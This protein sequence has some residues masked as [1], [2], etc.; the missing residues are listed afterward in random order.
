MRPLVHPRRWLLASPLVAIGC[1]QDPF[2]VEG[3]LGRPIPLATG[4]DSPLVRLA[5]LDEGCPGREALCNPE[6]ERCGCP[7]GDASRACVPLLVDSLAP[8][9]TLRSQDDGAEA[10]SLSDECLEIR[11]AA[12]LA[13]ADPSAQDLAS[14]VTRIRL[15]DLPVVRAPSSGAG[16]WTWSAGDES[17][18]IEPGGVLGGNVLARFAVEV[19]DRTPL[20]PTFALYREFPGTEAS[21]ANDG[22]AFLPVQ[23]PGRLLGRSPNDECDIGGEGCAEP[24]Y[25]PFLQERRLALVASRMVLDS[26]VAVP[27]C[28]VAY[29][30]ETDAPNDGGVCAGDPDPDQ[31]PRGVTGGID[32][33]NCTRATDS[34]GGGRP[35]SL[36]VATSVPGLV[37]F[38]DSTARLF[39]DPATLPPCS[40]DLTDAR[41]CLEGSDGALHL[42]GWP[43]AS[44]LFRLRVR[45]LA[46][47]PGLARTS[48]PDP[49][50]R[51]DR[52]LMAL[53]GQCEAFPLAVRDEEDLRNTT[54]PYRPRVRSG[55]TDSLRSYARESLAVVGEAW[56][57]DDQAGPEADR[58]IPTL[59]LPAGHPAAV[60]VRQ[61]VVPEAVQPDGLVGT[62]LF[63]ETD[64]VLDYTDTSPG[65]RLR[66]TQPH[67]GDCLVAPNCVSDATPACCHGLPRELLL[68]FIEDVGDDACCTALST[69]DLREIQQ[70]GEHC[71]GI[72][73]L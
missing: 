24:A 67:S 68:T 69:T 48:G 46:I 65:I 25:D 70:R 49:C 3:Q 42:S 37:L 58:W 71:Q 7:E 64:T 30:R 18:V 54:P 28:H 12:G 59:V 32:P 16:D 5:L 44:G 39:G 11:S 61:D 34:Q 22:R 35:A 55:P 23:F 45:S 2:V 50:T 38:D 56:W 47:V 14:A 8:L 36:V 66:C 29:D 53:R 17:T 73:P 13:A 4:D 26:C 6:T 57:R 40:G 52:R 33:Q 21:L 27:P 20:P 19:F 60:S 43:D 9:T 10:A 72:D 31:N 41:A 62:A 51:V 1:G 63:R 15:R